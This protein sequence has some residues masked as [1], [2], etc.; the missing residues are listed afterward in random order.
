M[1]DLKLKSN[2]GVNLKTEAVNLYY[3]RF[4]ALRGITISIPHRS[5]TAIIGPSGCGKST[6]LRIFNRMNDLIPGVRVEGKVELDGASIYEKNTDVVALRK[7]VGMVFQKPN[8]FPMSVLDNI[9]FGPRQHGVKRAAELE[10]IV[11]Q[12]LRQVG[13]WEEV[14]DILMQPALSLSAGQQQLLCI[15]RVLAVGPEVILMDEPC[16]ALDPDA[17]LRIEDLMRDLAQDYTIVIVTHNMEQAARISDMSAFIMMEEDKA[18]V[19][20]EYSPTA[21]LFSNPKD[22]RTD[23]YITGRFG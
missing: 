9:A 22:K 8:P 10:G 2:P 7:K 14:K 3:G 19:L 17:T 13:L 5:I 6:L 4:Q 23:D 12:S 11:E 1:D 20:V 15:A 16:S 18:G 21:Q